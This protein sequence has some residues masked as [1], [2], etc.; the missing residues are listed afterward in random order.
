MFVI[1]SR[2]YSYFF[3]CGL[4]VL[5]ICIYPS[6]YKLC[7]RWQSNSLT[8]SY[9]DALSIGSVIVFIVGHTAHNSSDQLK[10]FVSLLC[11]DQLKSSIIQDPNL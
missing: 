9:Q 10:I 4:L 5:Y 2:V 1:M 8:L 6:A 7:V 3:S 11:E